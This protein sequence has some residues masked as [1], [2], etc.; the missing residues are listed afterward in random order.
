MKTKNP[1][2]PKLYIEKIENDSSIELRYVQNS[3][4]SFGERI[5][6]RQILN[7]R[8]NVNLFKEN[9]KQLEIL[10]NYIIIQKRVLE[11]HQKSRNYDAVKI[12][13]QSILHMREFENKINS[14]FEK[15]REII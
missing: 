13:K 9:L 2:H 15:N 12:L 6:E 14:W 8:K 7:D 4:N 10:K 1:V 3:Y 11:K 5:V